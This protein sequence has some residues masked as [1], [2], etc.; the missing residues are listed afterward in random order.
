MPGRSYIHGDLDFAQQLVDELSGTG[1]AVMI[2]GDFWSQRERV[3]ADRI[4][5]IYVD[6]GTDM[7]VAT[8][9]AMIVYS[10]TETHIYP[11]RGE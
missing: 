1:E 11:R 2:G 8:N 10:K 7:E 3:T 4:I 5:G 9:K 6:P